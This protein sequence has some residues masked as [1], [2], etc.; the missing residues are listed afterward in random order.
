MD[1]QPRF[2]AQRMFLRECFLWLKTQWR[3]HLALGI[4]SVLLSLFW[5]FHSHSPTAFPRSG[6]LMTVAGVYM[7]YRGYFRGLDNSWAR[8]TGQADR[9]AFT[10]WHPTNSKEAARL[11]DR[12][13][14]RYGMMAIVVG[15]IIWAYGDCWIPNWPQ[16]PGH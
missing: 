4:G 8:E 7:M 6:A 14:F 3:F 2:Y 15:T 11:E 16:P 9:A 13:A 12:K 10:G 5:A 1:Q